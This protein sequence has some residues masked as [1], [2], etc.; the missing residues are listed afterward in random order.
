M[1]FLMCTSYDWQPIP[2]KKIVARRDGDIGAFI[3]S[4]LMFSQ[5]LLIARWQFILD[6][7]N[8]KSSGSGVWLLDS[9]DTYILI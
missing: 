9:T 7:T 3:L 8:N 5:L 4:F 1:T 2:C 6:F